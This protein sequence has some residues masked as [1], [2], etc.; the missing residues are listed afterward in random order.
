M[1][2]NKDNS[3]N[4]VESLKKVV[5]FD[6]NIIDAQGTIVFSKD[7]ILIGSLCHEGKAVIFS[8]K[9]KLIAEDFDLYDKN[10]N[11]RLII[12]ICKGGE[13][14]GAL[15]LYG[16]LS[17]L[18]S[19]DEFVSKICNR[20]ANSKET[21]KFIK[22]KAINDPLPSTQTITNNLQHRAEKALPPYTPNKFIT[23]YS[24][25]II[26]QSYQVASK[27]A[28]TENQIKKI[29]DFISCS[30]L[31]NYSYE[32]RNP[33]ELAICLNIHPEK[34]SFDTSTAIK[35]M[36]RL[37]KKLESLPWLDFNIAC[38]NSL[39]GENRV[40][41]SYQSALKTLRTGK[42][43]F[44]KERIYCYNDMALDVMFLEIKDRWSSKY[45]ID[46]YS[47]LSSSDKNGCLSKTLESL[48]LSNLN[49]GETANKLHIHRNTLRYRLEKIK[50]HT[51]LDVT[52]IDN[53]FV[54]YSAQK[55]N[56]LSHA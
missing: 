48:F 50:N 39:K 41:F 16:Y 29:I 51:G 1:H 7:E 12:P 49:L 15:D 55:F 40:E 44:P 38:G 22:P 28:P 10:I 54:L 33:H 52:N 53:L 46:T 8:K 45:I 19:A 36:H 47:S 31:R 43:L 20:I 26:I 35:K 56:Q 14:L 6:I 32:L 17:D 25:V 27:N 13:C 11:G 34:V 9:K 5:D 4:I 18:L 2:I 42:A 21:T 23:E 37:A 3:A 30:E 24:V